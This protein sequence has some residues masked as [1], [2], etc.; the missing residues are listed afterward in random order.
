[1]FKGGKLK[2]GIVT[3]SRSERGILDSLVR[4]S[5]NVLIELGENPL[6]SVLS[7]PKVDWLIV[8]GDRPEML[9]ATLGGAK[10]GFPIAHIH[11]GDM[12]DTGYIDESCRHSITRFAHIHFP[13]TQKSAENLKKMGEQEFRIHMVGSLAF[14][15]CKTAPFTCN[16]RVNLVIYNHCPK[17]NLNECVR[18]IEKK[19][20]SRTGDTI[21]VESNQDDQ[22]HDEK[23]RSL[24]GSKKIRF[25]PSMPRD[26]LL[27]YLSSPDCLLIGNSSAMYIEA[28]Y[29]ET[30]CYHVGTRNT[31]REKIEYIPD[32]LVSQTIV[33]VLEETKITDELMTKRVIF[34]G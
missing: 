30:Q 4:Q 10:R 8:I 28:Q 33:K 16:K 17:D 18:E 11:G 9:Q 15:G 19:I 5:D 32:G 31:G 13:A 2:L 6:Q 3:G 7:A 29:F 23:I 22:G 14:D 34:N 27:G 26:M 21:W 25:V 12:T 24:V 20:N 1:M